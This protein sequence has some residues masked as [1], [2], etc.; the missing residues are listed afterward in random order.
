MR[1]LFEYGGY[2]AGVILVA[3]GIGALTMSVNA[4]NEVRSNLAAEKI[5]GTPDSTIPGLAVNS[6]SRARAFAK[7]MRKHALE[8]SKGQTYSQMG[9]Y[10]DSSGKATSDLTKAAVD[11]TTKQP[12]TNTAR[13]VWV[14]ETA[15][16]TALNVSY[17]AEQL[18]LFGI[19]VGVA[20]LLSGIG[21]IVLAAVGRLHKDTA[22]T[23][24]VRD[25]SRSTVTA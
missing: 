17:M 20:L 21:F 23:G 6:G 13:N 18:S 25:E 11:P 14:T 4:R 10:L 2:I 16:S 7:V 12:V 1:K 22:H 9:Q 24:M 3:F 15:L 5:V 8:A 19:I